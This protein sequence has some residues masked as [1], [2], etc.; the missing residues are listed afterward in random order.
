M[1]SRTN[2]KN[3][4]SD[5]RELLFRMIP[6]KWESIYLYASVVENKNHIENGEMFFYYFPKGII[7]KNPV[8]V[9][10]VPA[11]FNID[12]NEYMKL[13]NQL[14]EYIKKLKHE[15][16]EIDK[17]YWSNITISIE[18]VE[19]LVEYNLDDLN[20]SLYTNDDRRMIWKYKY[21]DYP[22]EKLDKD[23]RKILKKYL[24]EEEIGQHGV[25]VYSETFYQKHI[26]NDIKYNDEQDVQ[27]LDSREDKKQIEPENSVEERGN[28]I[29]SQ[30]LKL[31]DN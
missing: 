8:N 1:E 16:I 3:L 10:E 19:F 9:Y 28:K 6:E 4:Y 14:Y 12:E 23:E 18:N 22:I 25:S 26:H 5:I 31:D 17:I 27:E 21:L 30:I 7:R 11:K 24:D 20:N 13:A 29:K 2:L 15:C